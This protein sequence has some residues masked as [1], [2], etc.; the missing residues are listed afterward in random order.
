MPSNAGMELPDFLETGADGGIRIKGHRL[1]L[2]DVA[3]RYDEGHSA[4][5]IVI[6]V[7]PTLS[8]PLVHK[9]IAFYLE[10]EQEVQAL[11]RKNVEEMTRQ[12][13]VP[14]DTPTFV[15]LRRRMEAKRRAEAS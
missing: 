4:E 6:D 9:V 10:H 15:E 12:A 13:A 3:A 2:V 14:Q 5:G 7:Y 1:C 11:L 8:L